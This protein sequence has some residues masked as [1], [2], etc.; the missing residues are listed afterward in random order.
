[1]SKSAKN[2]YEQT[3]VDVQDVDVV[4]FMIVL[5]TMNL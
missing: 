4:G 5:L 3:G 2:V 1:M